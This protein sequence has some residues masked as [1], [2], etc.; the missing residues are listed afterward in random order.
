MGASCSGVE[1]KTGL[2][3][4]GSFPTSTAWWEVGPEAASKP[5]LKLPPAHPPARR[6]A[7]ESR[8][9]PRGPA[10]LG[11]V[12]L[13][14]GGLKVL[15]EEG[16]PFQG[17]HSQGVEAECRSDPTL[18]NGIYFLTSRGFPLSSVPHHGSGHLSGGIH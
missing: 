7:A 2:G 15:M 10:L 4:F 8:R 11:S 18:V 9:E 6:G 3:R 1:G 17:G 14:D 12:T 13:R 5:R 16:R